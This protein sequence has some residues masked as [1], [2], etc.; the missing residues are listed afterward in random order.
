MQNEFSVSKSN[1]AF[2]LKKKQHFFLIKSDKWMMNWKLIILSVYSKFLIK[3]WLNRQPVSWSTCETTSDWNTLIHCRGD[4]GEFSK[5][6]IIFSLT[7]MKPPTTCDGLLDSTSPRLPWFINRSLY[8]LC[9]LQTMSCTRWGFFCEN[10]SSLDVFKSFYVII[11]TMIVKNDC[12]SYLLGRKYF[13]RVPTNTLST[14]CK[15]TYT[16]QP[17]CFPL[18]LLSKKIYQ[19][20]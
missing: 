3:L 14:C 11:C 4:G 20:V 15:K 6:M 12:S 13:C 16:P 18:P 19:F 17:G 2:S 7:P 8:K 9:S 5:A 10:R 1:L